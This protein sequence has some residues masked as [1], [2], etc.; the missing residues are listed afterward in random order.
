MQNGE[1]AKEAITNQQILSTYYAGRAGGLKAREEGVQY[2]IITIEQAARK[3]YQA[4]H[5]DWILYD[6]AHPPT[7]YLSFKAGYRDGYHRSTVWREKLIFQPEEGRRQPIF[8]S[9]YQ[10]EQSFFYSKLRG[11]KTQAAIAAREIR[12]TIVAIEESG[13]FVWTYEVDFTLPNPFGEV[14]GYVAKIVFT[15]DGEDFYCYGKTNYLNGHYNP[16]Y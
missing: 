7:D 12:E 9:V 14:L 10:I 1:Q 15:K 4:S 3:L 8:P 16:Y 11:E 13:L 6:A 2:N 5:P